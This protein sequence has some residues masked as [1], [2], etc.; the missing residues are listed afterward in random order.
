LRFVIAANRLSSIS[1]NDG[2]YGRGLGLLED[3]PGVGDTLANKRSPLID[4]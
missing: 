1:I 3:V 4:L 2:V